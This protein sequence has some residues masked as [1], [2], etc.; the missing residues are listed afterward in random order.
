MN[1]F[2][3]WQLEKVSNCWLRWAGSNYD[4][5]LKNDTTITCCRWVMVFWFNRF[6]GKPDIFHKIK[7]FGKSSQSSSEWQLFFCRW[8]T[9]LLNASPWTWLTTFSKIFDF[10]KNVWF[11]TGSILYGSLQ[12]A[13]IDSE[14]SSEWRFMV[15]N[16]EIQTG[17]KWS[18]AEL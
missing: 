18:F 7:D 3:E 2:F 12:L 5:R 9:T 16:L 14:S 17:R 4:T 6:C 11:S 15:G 10:V 8:I 1:E 13:L